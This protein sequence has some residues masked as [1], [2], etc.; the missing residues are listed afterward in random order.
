LDRNKL[1]LKMENKGINKINRKGQEEMF[2][3]VI[4]VVLVIIMGVILFVFS[5]KEKPLDT[6]Q[7]QAMADDF[8]H[9]LLSYTTDCLGRDNSKINIKDLIYNCKISPGYK[10][11]G[12]DEGY[13]S[14]L[15]K[16]LI[17]V[18]KNLL[19]NETIAD[20][21]IKGYTLRVYPL[22]QNITISRGNTIGSNYMSKEAS[23]L[24]VRSGEELYLRV[25]YYY[26]N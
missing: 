18:T 14:Y 4:I 25:T 16:T 24:I 23:G 22:Q 6:T 5:L 3:F 21:F 8:N 20:K 11:N 19:G 9:A 2:G 12:I 26:Q 17:N 13:C 15:N 7:K 10:C 1:I